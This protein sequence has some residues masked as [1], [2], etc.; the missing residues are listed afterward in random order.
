MVGAACWF[1]LGTLLWF[2]SVAWLRFQHAPYWVAWRERRRQRRDFAYARTLKRMHL[3]KIDATMFVEGYDQ[4]VDEIR[5][6]FA[7]RPDV[8]V[9]ID[10]IW[11]KE[12]T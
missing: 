4:A 2:I 6:H 1:V 10:K 9:E 5:E 3:K 11:R 7:K 12:N 8:A